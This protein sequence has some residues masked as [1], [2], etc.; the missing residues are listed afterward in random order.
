LALA[1]TLEGIV[2]DLRRAPDA[3]TSAGGCADQAADARDRPPVH[4]GRP[5]AIRRATK[6]L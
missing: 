6:H 1:L 4:T 2:A 3:A 5:R